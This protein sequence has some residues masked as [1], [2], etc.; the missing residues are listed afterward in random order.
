MQYVVDENYSFKKKLV[1]YFVWICFVKV[2]FKKDIQ[3]ETN[4]KKI[5]FKITTTSTRCTMV[6]I[7]SPK[8]I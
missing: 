3:R 1:L 2:F 6:N 8:T 4:G 7:D 5:V